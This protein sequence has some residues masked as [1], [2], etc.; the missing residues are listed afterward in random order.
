MK[1][2]LSLKLLIVSLVAVV[3]A[4]VGLIAI[5]DSTTPP[6][7]DASVSKLVPTH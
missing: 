3:V 4:F 7:K 6:S 5:G 1:K 2:N